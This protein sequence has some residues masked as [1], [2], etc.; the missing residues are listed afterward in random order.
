MH[1]LSCIQAL[2]ENYRVGQ[3][4]T[5]IDPPDSIF[6]SLGALAD[7]PHI[8]HIGDWK[9]ENLYDILKEEKVE[10]GVDDHWLDEQVDGRGDGGV[11]KGFDGWL[12]LR[13]AVSIKMSHTIP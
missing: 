9:Y 11:G 4:T 6:R 2:W 13:M 3:P 5:T 12:K 7:N 1:V 8:K 10:W